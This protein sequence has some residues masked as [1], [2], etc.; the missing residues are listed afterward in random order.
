MAMSVE[1]K[2][3]TVFL[4]ASQSGE[5]RAAHAAS[6]AKR[7][8]AQLVGV[9]VVFAGMKLPQLPVAMPFARRGEALAQLIDYRN[10]LYFDAEAASMRVHEHFETLCARL[11]VAG[12]FR[13][14]Y[15][16]ES[17]HEAIRVA[18]ASDL[19]VVGHPKHSLPDDFSVEKLLRT[20]P[21]PLLIVPDAWEGES[22]GNRILV[23]WNATREARRAVTDAMGFLI[24]ARSV[25]ILVVDSSVS[26][27]P[28]QELSSEIVVDLGR[29]GAHVGL[30]HVP[31][32]GLSTP[33]VLLA[34]AKDH[35][36][37]LLVVGAYS[38]SRLGE[39]LL[40]G[41]TRTLLARTTVPTFMSR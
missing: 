37:D 28:G 13:P 16:E 29:H 24:A 27:Q 7:W 19:V 2:I 15:P 17:T 1:P 25:T 12:E 22:I 30:Y 23:G 20:S 36:A 18:L 4:D 5:K 38:H 10:Q 3:V 8:D 21:A 35:A 6:L 34:Y 33:E 9:H 11:K 31:S 32:H 26:F 39:L 14:L 41:T 40:G